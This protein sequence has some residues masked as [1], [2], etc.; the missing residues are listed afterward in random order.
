MPVVDRVAVEAVPVIETAADRPVVERS[1]AVLVR[2]RREMPLAGSNSRIARGPQHLGERHR[3]LPDPA[4][5]ARVIGPSPL[6]DV[7]DADRVR[8]APGQQTRSRRC[9]ERRDVEVVET[10]ARTG[11]PVHDRCAMLGAVAAEVRKADVV[12][13]RDDDV[14]PALETPG[15]PALVAD[16]S[17]L[18]SRSNVRSHRT[19]RGGGAGFQKPSSC[20]AHVWPPVTGT[21]S[22]SCSQN[23]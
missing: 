1:G 14:R 12:E 13:Y 19:G 8:V 18:V 22:F 7:A 10:R 9:A 4:A 11:E 6:G 21:Q 20:D 16:R 15:L 17:G 3:V 23:K 2:E 5:I